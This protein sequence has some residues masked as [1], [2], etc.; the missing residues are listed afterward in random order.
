MPSRWA[1]LQS[2]GVESSNCLCRRWQCG[3]GS[4]WGKQPDRPVA[5]CMAPPHSRPSAWRAKSTKS[6]AAGV[7]GS[8]PRRGACR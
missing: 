7:R 6:G 1:L 8:P 4:D 2:W 5:P 3:R